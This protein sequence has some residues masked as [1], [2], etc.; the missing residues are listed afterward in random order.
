M[1][2][3]AEKAFSIIKKLKAGGNAE[4]E[5]ACSN[6][7]QMASIAVC[8]A[9]KIRGATYKKPVRQTELAKKWQKPT[10]GG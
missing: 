4:L 6:V 1:Q 10:A 2:T 3:D 7:K 5:M 8:N 9:N